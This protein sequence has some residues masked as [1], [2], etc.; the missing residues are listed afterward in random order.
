MNALRGVVDALHIGAARTGELVVGELAG[1]LRV[2][3]GTLPWHQ[4]FVELL[5]LVEAVAGGELGDLEVVDDQAVAGEDL[6]VVVDDIDNNEAVWSSP[7]AYTWSVVGVRP[8]PQ[9][10]HLSILRLVCGHDVTC[11]PEDLDAGAARRRYRCDCQATVGGR[12][13]G[14]GGPVIVEDQAGEDLEELGEDLEELGEDLEELGE[15]LEGVIVDDQAVAG[16]ELGEDVEEVVEGL[17]V[18]ELGEDLAEVQA[19]E[20]LEGVI[21]EDQAVAGVELGEDVEGVVVDDQAVAGGE[22]GEDNEGVDRRRKTLRNRRDLEFKIGGFLYPEAV[23]RPAKRA[24]CEVGLR[25][26]PFISCRHHIAV[27]VNDE[28]G[29]LHLTWPGVELWNLSASCSLDVAAEGGRTLDEIADVLNVT[30][31]R[32]RQIQAGALVKIRRLSRTA[33]KRELAALQEFLSDE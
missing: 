8:H 14:R 4:R 27:D 33:N 9:K 2:P 26:C 21:V 7:H 24:E 12:R 16:V 22:V 11:G 15:D 3:R 31:E 17:A 18:A 10:P 23:T 32:V 13:R 30:R 5:A 28:A 29:S 19:V 1:A 6:A 25:P 20:D